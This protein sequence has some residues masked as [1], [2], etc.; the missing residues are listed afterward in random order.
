MATYIMVSSTAKL[1][2]P[3]RLARSL[4]LL[5][6]A[7]I[8]VMVLLRNLMVVRASGTGLEGLKNLCGDMDPKIKIR[9]IEEEGE[10]ALASS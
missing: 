9:A 4:P 7:Q 8:V 10:R 5:Q 1:T 6:S 2:R 3:I